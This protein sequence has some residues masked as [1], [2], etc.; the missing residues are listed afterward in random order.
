VKSAAEVRLSNRATR[1]IDHIYDQTEL[2]WGSDQAEKYIFD[3]R[4]ACERLSDHPR[5]GRPAHGVRTGYFIFKSGSHNIFFRE[6][7]SGILVIRIL[8]QR[9]DFKRHL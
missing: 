1:D 6:D 2:N 4:S 3:I 7:K 8:H 5:P 9:M